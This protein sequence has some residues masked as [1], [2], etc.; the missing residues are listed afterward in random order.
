MSFPNNKKTN[1]D[2]VVIG[3]GCDR[4]KGQE[5]IYSCIK[6]VRMQPRSQALSYDTPRGFQSLEQEKKPCVRG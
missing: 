3:L 1:I 6:H 4:D 5:Q 2:R